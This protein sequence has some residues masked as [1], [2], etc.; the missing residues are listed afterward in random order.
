[1]NTLVLVFYVVFCTF[2]VIALAFYCGRKVAENRQEEYLSRLAQFEK[3]FENLI[4]DMDVRVGEKLELASET[5]AKLIEILEV[6]DRKLLEMMDLQQ[7]VEN[8][9]ARLEKER[10][11]LE[12]CVLRAKLDKKLLPPLETVSLVPELPLQPVP[13]SLPE[14][15][16]STEADRFVK[17]VPISGK[18]RGRRVQ[19]VVLDHFFSPPHISP[20]SNL[21]PSNEEQDPEIA[22]LIRSLHELGLTPEEIARESHLPVLEIRTTLASLFSHDEVQS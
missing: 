6:A 17:K 19:K 7:E 2:L 9:R 22:E 1:M 11:E 21:I 12:Q 3:R 8:L 20:S 4:E 5:R 14:V 13:E 10:V 16:S 15:A 18:E